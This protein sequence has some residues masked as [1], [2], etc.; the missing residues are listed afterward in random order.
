MT[1]LSN[2]TTFPVHLQEAHQVRKIRSVPLHHSEINPRSSDA[3]HDGQNLGLS[4]RWWAA[5]EANQSPGGG[6][7]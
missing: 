6:S 3:A 2:N 4:R 7:R 5:S 1:A